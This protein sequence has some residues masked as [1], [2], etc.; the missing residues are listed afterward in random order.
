MDSIRTQWLELRVLREKNGDSLT[1]LS[2]RSTVSLSYL[3]QLESGDREP[4]VVVTKKL[5]I[6]LNVPLSVLEKE[7][8]IV[9]DLG[10]TEHAEAAAS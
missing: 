5:A 7:R 2:K 1:S 6:A 3:S 9:D 8:R 4:N 10:L